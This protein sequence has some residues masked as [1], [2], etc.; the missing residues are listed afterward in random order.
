MEIKGWVFD[1]VHFRHFLYSEEEV[2]G[3]ARVK[4]PLKKLVIDACNEDRLCN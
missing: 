2:H 4:R 3:A 1:G